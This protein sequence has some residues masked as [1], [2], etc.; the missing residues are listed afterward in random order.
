MCVFSS[1]D[2]FYDLKVVQGRG[3]GALVLPQLADGNLRRIAFNYE[4]M[5]G[6]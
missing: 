1:E 4:G 6:N 2:V 3:R 5:E